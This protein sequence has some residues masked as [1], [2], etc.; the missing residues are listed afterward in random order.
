MSARISANALVARL[1]CAICRGSRASCE[2]SRT[3]GSR[4][5]SVSKYSLIA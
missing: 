2:R 5:S 3:S 4:V 1:A